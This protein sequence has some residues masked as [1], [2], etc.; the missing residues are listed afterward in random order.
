MCDAV[1]NFGSR[2]SLVFA[3]RQR[4]LAQIVAD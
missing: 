2:S 4:Q 1:S 3:H